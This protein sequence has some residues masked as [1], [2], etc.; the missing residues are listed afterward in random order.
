MIYQ[1]KIIPPVAVPISFGDL[2]HSIPF[3]FGSKQSL[4]LFKEQISNYAGYKH[5]ILFPSASLGLK[6]ILELCRKKSQKNEVII[7]AYSCPS[8]YFSVK[9]AGLIPV[10]ADIEI[11]TLD[12]SVRETLKK[13]NGQTLAIITVNM[14][15]KRAPVQE[16]ISQVQPKYPNLFI[17]EDSAQVIKT[18]CKEVNE[19]I[20]ADFLVY[21]FGR[22]KPISTLSGGA[23]ATDDMEIAEELNNA[24]NQ[25]ISQSWL[26]N[27][28][29]FVKAGFYGIII[30]PTFYWITKRLLDEHYKSDPF[31]LISIQSHFLKR[32]IFT[33]FQ[34]LLGLQMLKHLPGFNQH[35]L[36]ISN[37]YSE[38]LNRFSDFFLPVSSNHGFLRYPVI[39]KNEYA[40]RILKDTMNKSGFTVSSGN[41][42]VLSTLADTPGTADPLYPV[43][44]LV[45]SNII[46]LPTHPLISIKR[47]KKFGE[48]LISK[49]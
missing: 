27:L 36:S 12:L 4:R 34:A 30:H 13:I 11:D 16:L 22:A 8:V 29:Q 48:I 32:Q 17:I 24:A 20:K 26:D 21:S 14:F 10:F 49:S 39:C 31:R 23:V 40:A 25:F 19:T 45:S 35:R 9:A 5:S 18:E 41:Y 6:N 7:P 42:P 33:S 46:T 43:S 3:I 37:Q 44:S 15:G 1:K 47:V 28:T 2:V 38:I